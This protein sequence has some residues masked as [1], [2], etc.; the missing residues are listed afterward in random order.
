MKALSWKQF[1]M[2]LSLVVITACG[3]GGSYGGGTSSGAPTEQEEQQISNF[4]TRI[5]NQLL[6]AG[7]LCDGTQTTTDSSGQTVTCGVDQWL[8]TL[9]TINTCTDGGACT[10]VAVIPFVAD[11]TPSDR[12]ATPEAFF[13]DIEPASPVSSAQA[14]TIDNFL[15]RVDQNTGETT[16]VAK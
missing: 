16:V 9:D 15:V 1:I 8:I 12:P 13:F 10:E 7:S 6:I 5:N 11:L 14:S 2:I 4:S 3:G